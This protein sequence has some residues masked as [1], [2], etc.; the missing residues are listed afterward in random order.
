MSLRGNVRFTLEEDMVFDLGGMSLGEHD[1][2]MAGLQELEDGFLVWHQYVTPRI[3][4]VRKVKVKKE[5]PGRK[6]T[7][8]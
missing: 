7:R 5:K 3:L 4:K 1:R 8:T 6:R 2:T